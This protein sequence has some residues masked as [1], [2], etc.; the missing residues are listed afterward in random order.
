MDG[1]FYSPALVAILRQVARDID[2]APDFDLLIAGD[3]GYQIYDLRLISEAAADFV[4]L[5]I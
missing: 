2:A 1:E 5:S 4:R 3:D